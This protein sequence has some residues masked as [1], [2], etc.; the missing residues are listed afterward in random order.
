[1][2]FSMNI[3]EHFFISQLTDKQ[4]FSKESTR[5][6]NMYLEFYYRQISKNTSMFE[7]VQFVYFI[8]GYH[9]TTINGWPIYRGVK[10]SALSIVCL[11]GLPEQCQV[12]PPRQVR[13]TNVY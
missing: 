11:A 9:I 2:P 6:N 13:V 10:F 7:Q 12:K 1:M 5:Q 4:V 8:P 3:L